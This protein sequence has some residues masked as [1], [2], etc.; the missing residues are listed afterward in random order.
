MLESSL[1][2]SG[3]YFVIRESAAIFPLCRLVQL[4]LIILYLGSLQ[5]LAD[6]LFYFSSGLTNFEESGVSLVINRVGVNARPGG[7][8]RR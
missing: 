4:D 3:P 2:E 5:L 7:R 6:A 1:N 8:L